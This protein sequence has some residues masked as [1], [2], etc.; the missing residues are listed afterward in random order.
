[1]RKLHLVEAGRVIYYPQNGLEEEIIRCFKNHRREPFRYQVE[2]K[3]VLYP[4]IEFEEGAKPVAFRFEKIELNALDLLMRPVEQGCSDGMILKLTF[5]Y[6]ASSHLREI[7]KKGEY[8]DTGSGFLS[9]FSLGGCWVRVDAFR[10]RVK[11]SISFSKWSRKPS[12]LVK[13]I[14]GWK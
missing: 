8:K 12:E 5:G 1:M 10:G 13:E 7:A 9:I 3:I 2:D 11:L 6:E 4:V 14:M